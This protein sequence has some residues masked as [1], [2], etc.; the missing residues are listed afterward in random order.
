MLEYFIFIAV[1]TLLLVGVIKLLEPGEFTHQVRPPKGNTTILN[2]ANPSTDTVTKA[3]VDSN[4]EKLGKNAIEKM[5]DNS[6]MGFLG[7]V[8]NMDDEINQY[9][10]M[11]AG[12][13]ELL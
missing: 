12:R 13:R 9:A 11:E 6:L 8:N 1:F 4:M 10:L 2:C 7:I 5:G 3:S